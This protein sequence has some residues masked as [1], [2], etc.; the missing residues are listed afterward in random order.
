[1]NDEIR[2]LEAE[3]RE[4]KSRL[5]M[6]RRAAPREEVQDFEFET[7]NGINK[8]SELFGEKFE[9]VVIHNMGQSCTYCTLWADGLNGLVPHVESRCAL[10]LC[11]PDELSKQKEFA[12]ARNWGYQMVR[13][14]SNEFSGTMGF[15][16]LEQGFGPG[17]STFCKIG[18]K[19]YRTGHTEFGPGDDFCGIWPLM[20]LLGGSKGWEPKYSYRKTII[21]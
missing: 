11:S 16:T 20:D 3:L 7:L 13:D 18:E 21:K 4:L 1:M 14:S 12:E 5:A 9:L 19:I 10:V 6:A 2:A 17:V 15:W 8:L